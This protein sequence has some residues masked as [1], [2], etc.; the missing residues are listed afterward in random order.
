MHASTNL[1]LGIIKLSSTTFIL[2][3]VRLSSTTFIIPLAPV[4]YITHLTREN[5]KMSKKKYTPF[6]SQNGNY[7]QHTCTFN[8]TTYI[9][10]FCLLATEFGLSIIYFFFFF[11]IIIYKIQI[12]TTYFPI[13]NYI[14]Q[15]YFPVNALFYA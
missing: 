11:I 10:S 7:K 3:L 4:V 9:S 15:L 2:P 14:N 8:L 6:H 1:I 13:V 12:Y 5:I